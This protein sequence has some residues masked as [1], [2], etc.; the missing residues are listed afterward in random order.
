M[1]MGVVGPKSR[2]VGQILE[3]PCLHSSGHIFDPIFIK[4]ARDV[5]FDKWMDPIE[6]GC[7]RIKK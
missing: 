1:N 7:G 6:N 3:K 2:S 4:L 5:Y